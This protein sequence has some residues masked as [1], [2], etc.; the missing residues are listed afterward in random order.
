M[1]KIRIIP[2]LIIVAMFSFSLRLVDLMSGLS[3]PKAVSYAA[4]AEEPEMAPEKAV[5]AEDGKTPE[6][7][8]VEANG[9]TADV[10]PDQMAEEKWQDPTGGA[11]SIDTV[12]QEV[13]EDLK[14]RRKVIE[15]SERELMAREALLKAAEN[16]LEQKYNELTQLRNKLE[17]MIDDQSE[18]E[19]KRVARLVKIYEGMKPKQAA[20]IFDTLDLDILVE[21]VSKMSE[22]KLSPILASMNPER[23]KTVTIML[24]EHNTLSALE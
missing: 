5:M 15:K 14:K 3:A 4:E 6:E 17:E 9:K 22:R 21:V 12:K 10:P 16:E 2:L 8:M 18:E 20:Q 19:K 24:A 1:F 11:M 23:A 13:F 7:P